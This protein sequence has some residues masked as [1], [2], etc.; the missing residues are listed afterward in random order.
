M[1]TSIAERFTPRLQERQ[2]QHLYRTRALVT[3]PQQPIMQI[4]GLTV[5]NF[6]SNDYLGLANSSAIKDALITE[7]NSTL[8]GVGAGAA[9]LVTGHH[10]HHHLLEDEL[11]DWLG[12]ERALLFSTGYMANLA[13]QQTLMQA[14]DVIIGD[15]LNHASLVDGA[16]ASSAEFKRYP[17]NDMAALERRLQAAAQQHASCTGQALI[18]TDGVFSM[19]GDIA[20]L[21]TIQTLAQTYQAWLMVDD[22]HGFGALGQNGKGSFEHLGLTPDANTIL[23]GT[24]GKAFGTSGAF[25]AGSQ[26]LI[27]S[28]IQFARPYIYTTA[29]SQLNAAASRAALKQVQAAQVSRETLAQ[30]IRQFRQGAQ[31]LGLTLIDS[32]S[33]IQPILLGDA[34]TALAW[35]EQL[36]QRGFWVGAIRP[37]TVP[38]GQARLRVT[39]CSTHTTAQIEALLAAFCDILAQQKTTFTQ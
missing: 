17:H 35:S 38:Q 23:V 2:H 20:P 27:E 16:H 19:D 15:K 5:V 9:H 8:S 6:S 29:M 13:V 21:K 32:P 26:V 33:A 24:L 34:H 1:S 31:A 18:V 7:L 30:H 14:G 4:N 12:T 25:V 3:S 39:L 11:A 36:K 28:L 37:P 10:L 22:A